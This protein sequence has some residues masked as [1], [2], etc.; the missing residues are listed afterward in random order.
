MLLA[1]SHD[2]AGLRH[3]P[4]QVSWQDA[5]FIGRRDALPPHFLIETDGFIFTISGNSLRNMNNKSVISR[6]EFLAAAVVAGAA[7]VS[8]IPLAVEPAPAKRFPLIFFSK[9][10]QQL[11]PADTAELV[12][13]A[14]LDG[15]E[16]PV[17][18]AG[19]VLP[20]RVE[21]DL[22]KMVEALAKCKLTLPL[23]VTDILKP[24]NPP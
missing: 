18:K 13:E 22:P 14:G 7:A 9:A 24:G 21:D 5:R 1:A 6:R 3:Q 17:R 12:A 11:S 23:I 19:Q 16:C 2:T 15:I 10:I 8:P 4:M 20:E